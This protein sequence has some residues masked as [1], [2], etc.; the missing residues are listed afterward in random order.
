MRWTQKNEDLRKIHARGFSEVFKRYVD[1]LKL[2]QK[3]LGEQTGISRQEISTW[4]KGEKRPPGWLDAAALAAAVFMAMLERKKDGVPLPV[5]LSF[6]AAAIM[7]EFLNAAGFRLTDDHEAEPVWNRLQS[8]AHP[9]PGDTIPRLRVG[10]F[11]WG[12][13]ARRNTAGQ[14]VG[15]SAELC[16]KVCELLGIAMESVPIEL[17][18]AG[19]KLQD[20]EVDMVAPLIRLPARVLEFACSDQIPELHAGLSMLAPK[21]HVHLFPDIK[22]ESPHQWRQ[23][24]WKN[25][26]V[27]LV[28]D[29]IAHV[30]LPFIATSVNQE[31]H[32]NF[33]D[34][35][36]AVKAEPV[37]HSTSLIRVFMGDE[38]T[39]H[40][41]SDTKFEIVVKDPYQLPLAFGVASSE[42]HLLAAINLCLS[43]IT[44]DVKRRNGFAHF[45][46]SPAAA[47]FTLNSEFDSKPKK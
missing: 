46:N 3:Q 14:F 24:P 30:L 27:C 29:G 7:K 47:G 16:R 23:V 1:A 2:E 10:Y 40:A 4:C 45:E 15:L 44:C 25:L 31:I 11:A 35:W 43:V 33:E 38:V 17:R 21:E 5:G 8:K 39:C 13:F 32:D 19:R 18:E 41:L 9:Q 34:A 12:N 22:S 36:N 37:E 42:T 20:R 6:D 28:R 26:K